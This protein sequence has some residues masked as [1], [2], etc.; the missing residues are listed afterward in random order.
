M[1]RGEVFVRT[2]TIVIAALLL[3]TFGLGSTWVMLGRQPGPATPH[4][5]EKLLRAARTAASESARSYVAANPIPAPRGGESPAER[6]AVL[7]AWF[8]AF[9][10]TAL[11]RPSGDR[12]ARDAASLAEAQARA[13]TLHELSQ[14][15]GPL[16][17][18][19][20]PIVCAHARLQ[21]AEIHLAIAKSLEAL[22]VPTYLTPEQQASFLTETGSRVAAQETRARIELEVAQ[23]LE[24]RI[25]A[26]SDVLE[27]IRA[28]ERELGDT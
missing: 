21:R 19:K 22:P 25:P 17:D 12:A 20:D 26:S 28:L 27:H 15:Y 18:D 24:D 16:A 3:A 11:T 4:Q 9:Q 5:S 2:T 7:D 13:G 1:G 23:D 6:L 14:A 8:E 10:D